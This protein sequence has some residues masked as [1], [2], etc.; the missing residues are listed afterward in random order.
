MTAILN[1][2]VKQTVFMLRSIESKFRSGAMKGSAGIRRAVSIL[3]L[4]VTSSVLGSAWE[5]AIESM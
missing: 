2:T 3:I 1:A 4:W 5:T